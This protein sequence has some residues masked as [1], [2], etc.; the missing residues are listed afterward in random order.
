MNTEFS[1]AGQVVF[2]QG[3]GRQ[4]GPRLAQA[5]AARGAV[6]AACDL[7]P[8][9]LTPIEAA[10]Q[11]LPGAVHTYI[12]DTSRGMPARAILDE[13]AN[14]CGPIDILINNPRIAPDKHL[15]D[16]DEYD[17]QRT[18][19]ANLNGSFLL[20]RLVARQMVEENRGVMVNLLAEPGPRL[21]VPGSAAY[22]ASQMGLLALTRAAAQELIAYNIRVYG[23][24]LPGGPSASEKAPE[25]AQ[26]IG[27]LCSADPASP[28]NPCL[29]EDW[30]VFLCSQVAE[31]IPGQV[32]R[33]SGRLSEGLEE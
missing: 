6:V 21:A 27:E 28:Q 12:G 4:P 9:L 7:S 25:R 17:W 23:V 3:A 2:I 5:F 18:I 14:E 33:L 20:M 29:V 30:V 26:W 19:E 1:F 32:F 16:T 10:C 24:C 11:G 13:V 15:L 22:A 31:A 8:S